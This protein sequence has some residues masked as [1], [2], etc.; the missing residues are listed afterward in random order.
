M[1]ATAVPALGAPSA[2]HVAGVI[3]RG[4]EVLVV[5]GDDVDGVQSFAAPGGRVEFGESAERDLARLVLEQTGARVSASVLLTTITR[6]ISA[7][8]TSSEQVTW[9]FACDVDATATT[10][11]TRSSV[12][13]WQPLQQFR[14][15]DALLFPAGLL[16]LI[17]SVE[18]PRD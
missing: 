14:D 9:I 5:R 6:M 17:D 4:D 7:F 2:E 11:T 1:S 13:S 18:D 15:D 12:A 8:G 3:R 10:A 16:E